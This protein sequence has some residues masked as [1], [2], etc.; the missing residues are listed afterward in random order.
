MR[1]NGCR[2]QEANDAKTG[3]SEAAKLRGLL[4]LFLRR[5]DCPLGIDPAMVTAV[6][7]FYA[8]FRQSLDECNSHKVEASGQRT[9]GISGAI[10]LISS[11]MIPPDQHWIGNGASVIQVTP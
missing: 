1:E 9:S 4:F 7:E 8:A 10:D 5:L 11:G 6:G 2:W 3:F